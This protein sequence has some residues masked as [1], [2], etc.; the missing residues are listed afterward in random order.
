MLILCELCTQGTLVSYVETKIN[1]TSK[2]IDQEFP[3]SEILIILSD[4]ILG[5]QHLHQ[6][7]IT[8]RD[9][10]VENILYDG[11]SFKLADFGS[12]SRL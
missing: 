2:D 1:N 8:H 6:N 3:E 10:K 9:L 11:K 7:G 4:I 12:A 5:V